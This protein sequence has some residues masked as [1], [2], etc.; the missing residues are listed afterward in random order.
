MEVYNL[1]DIGAALWITAHLLL[2]WHY[3]LA[4]Q[5]TSIGSIGFGLYLGYRFNPELTPHLVQALGGDV[6]FANTIA[7]FAITVATYIGIRGVAYPF[8]KLIE[9]KE[10]PLSSPNRIMGSVVGTMIACLVLYLGLSAIT[11]VNSRF[12]GPLAD[13][14]THYSESRAVQFARSHNALELL[15]LHEMS[16]LRLIAKG[17]FPS[18]PEDSADSPQLW[19]TL[20]SE[21]EDLL[22]PDTIG[23]IQAGKWWSIYQEDKV[24]FFLESESAREWIALARTSD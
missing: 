11:A 20:L 17:T 10:S 14:S 2:G 1:V 15:H 24:L 7:F 8:R 4:R 18:I 21:A 9:A 3:G 19:D 23:L 13:W 22:N 16:L 5:V 12:G 6:P